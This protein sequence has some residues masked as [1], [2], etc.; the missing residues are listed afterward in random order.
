MKEN[1]NGINYLATLYIHPTTTAKEIFLLM[2][3]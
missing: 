2:M 1:E 3:L